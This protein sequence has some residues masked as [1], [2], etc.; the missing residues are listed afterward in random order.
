MAICVEFCLE[1]AHFS[2][3]W[4]GSS[5][6]VSQDVCQEFFSNWKFY[7]FW[8][9]FRAVGDLRLVWV[10]YICRGSLDGP[11]LCFTLDERI[12]CQDWC[13]MHCSHDSQVGCAQKAGKR[14]IE[15]QGAFTCRASSFWDGWL[16]SLFFYFL[17]IDLTSARSF[18]IKKI[19]FYL[20][21]PK[22]QNR[23]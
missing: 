10:T 9:K 18:L 16:L 6:I 22:S 1:L 3:K 17:E 5:L 11:L 2:R 15:W 12:Q 20:S 7:K 21:E 13:W 4:L 14:D 8:T 23:F 19:D